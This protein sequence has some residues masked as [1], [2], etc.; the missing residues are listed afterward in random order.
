MLFED[1]SEIWFHAIFLYLFLVANL[2]AAAISSNKVGFLNATMQIHMKKS[3]EF[4]RIDL[5]LLSNFEQIPKE[6]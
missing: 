6:I 4:T 5:G 2:G 3:F 1:G